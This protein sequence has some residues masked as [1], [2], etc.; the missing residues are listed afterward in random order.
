MREM[1]AVARLQEGMRFEAES[2][3]GH[4]VTMDMLDD[5]EA[6]TPSAGFSP[7]EMLLLG[8]AGCTGISVLSILRKR[9]QEITGYELRVHGIRATT[10]P[11]VFVEITVEHVLTGHA[12]KPE[13]VA[14]ALELSETRYC[15]VE[16]MLGKTAQI[17]HTYRLVDVSNQ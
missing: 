4:R 16:A 5:H 6:G 3:S 2:G 12:L 15:G 17:M 1:D 7:M 8:L 13:A 9:K 14:R 11:Q 10:H